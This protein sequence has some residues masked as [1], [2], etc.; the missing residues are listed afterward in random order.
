M[1]RRFV[2]LDVFTSQRFTG[3]PLAVVLDAEGLD[4][5]AMQAIA[6]EFVL[7]ETVFV[8]PPAD[9]AH[10]AQLRIFTPTRELPFAG[11]PTVG[12]AV[13]LARLDGVANDR[14]IVI[15]ETVGPVHCRIAP[16]GADSG[17]ARF[18]LPRLPE[19]APGAVDAA[20]VAAALGL[21]E[22]D[23]GF[24]R[25]V[26]ENWTAGVAFT[27]V[28][29]KGLV[30]V[31]RAKPDMSRWDTAFGAEGHPAAF[32]FSREAVEPGHAFHARMFAP[33]LGIVED[34]ATGAAVAAFAGAV[35]RHGGL[36]DGDHELVIEQGFEMGRPSLITLSLA[37]R[38]GALVSAAIG[39]EAVVVSEGRLLA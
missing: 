19:P 31:S 33:S 16:R 7:S 2:T 5:A 25:F 29:V 39:G 34:P 14:E 37:M 3:N 26:P 9:G 24:G 23:V 11:H 8:L 22:S 13:L 30:A 18:D 28:P 36:A 1:A 27:L 38:S 32:V 6:R 21:A 35:A 4:A 20:A 12:A 10:R 15:E 17:R